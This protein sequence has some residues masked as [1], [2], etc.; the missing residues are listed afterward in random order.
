MSRDIHRRS[1]YTGLASSDLIQEHVAL[2]SD[3]RNIP[4]D[5]T[6][7]GTLIYV[8]Q[9]LSL[10]AFNNNATDTPDGGPV[11]S[12]TIVNREAII[13]E[14]KSDRLLKIGRKLGGFFKRNS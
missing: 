9:E 6:Q 14:P 8:T 3:L 13:A 7:D 5:D 10:F 4:T 2:I 1:I 11:V 12:F